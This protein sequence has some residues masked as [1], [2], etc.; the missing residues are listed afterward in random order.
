[1]V[2][3]VEVVS[4]VELVAVVGTAAASVLEPGWRALSEA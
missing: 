2:V 3:V 4:V 1:M